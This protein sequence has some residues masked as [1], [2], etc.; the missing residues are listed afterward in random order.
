MISVD[1]KKYWGVQLKGLQ[2]D[3]LRMAIT[4]DLFWTDGGA[5]KEARLIFHSVTS[6]Q[7]QAEKIFESEVVEL[8]SLEA[9]QA[10][11]CLR[12]S[13][14]LSNYEFDIDCTEVEDNGSNELNHAHEIRSATQRPLSLNCFVTSQVP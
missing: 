14:E 1:L 11:K 7:F 2:L 8:V 3:H 10:G 13:G 4:M 6:C 5:P 12:I 9:K